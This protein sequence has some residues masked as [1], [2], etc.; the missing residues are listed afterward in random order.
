MVSGAYRRPPACGVSSFYV[1]VI[2]ENDWIQSIIKTPRPKLQPCPANPTQPECPCK[3]Y[4][5]TED[6]FYRL[7]SE[8]GFVYYSK[9]HRL[10]LYFYK[11]ESYSG[12]IIRRVYQFRKSYFYDVVRFVLAKLIPFY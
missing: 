12:W 1:D 3:S 6:H 8:E 9:K 2:R 5:L 4:R 7:E 10:F 11:T